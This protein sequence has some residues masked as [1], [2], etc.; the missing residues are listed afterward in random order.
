MHSGELPAS[1]DEL[2]RLVETVSTRDFGKPFLHRCRFN[3]RLRTSGGR[4]LL[5]THEL[6]FNPHY[7]NTAG[8]AVF[9]GT[10]RHELCHYHLHLAGRGYRHRDRDFKRLLEQVRGSRYADTGHLRKSLPD[11]YE[12][13]CTACQ[14]V[15][16]RKRRL[17][18]RR[19]V[20]GACHGTLKLAATLGISS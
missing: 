5:S 6:E 20:C 16:R 15:F 19:Y 3:P 17:N 18:V 8:F 2:Q 7:M 10:V 9:I 12:Y 14:Q 11:R 1:D 4:Y 13:V